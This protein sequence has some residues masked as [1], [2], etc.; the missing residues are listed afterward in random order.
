MDL[1]LRKENYKWNALDF[2][3]I[4]LIY[5]KAFPYKH[6]MRICYLFEIV[7]QCISWKKLLFIKKNASTFS[8]YF[9]YSVT[10]NRNVNWDFLKGKYLISM[11]FTIMYYIL[12]I[13]VATKIKKNDDYE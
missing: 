5:F 1:N 4:R 9:L 12:F 3:F 8:I 6:T 10:Q 7:F 11:N 13:Y 2:F